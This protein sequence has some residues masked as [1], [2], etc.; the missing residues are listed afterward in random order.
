MCK[1]SKPE[2]NLWLNPDN[3]P[4]SQTPLKFSITY[5]DIKRAEDRLR[6][7]APLLALLFPELRMTNGIIES[8]LI[9]ISSSSPLPPT[10]NLWVKADHALPIAGSIKARG[11]I[12]EVLEFAEQLALKEGLITTQSSYVELSQPA[13]KKLFSQYTIAVGSTGNLGLSIGVTAAA[14]GFKAVV[15]MSKEAKSWKKTHLRQREVTVIEHEGD[16]A[17][18]VQRGREQAN[19]NPHSY[20][21]DDERSTSLFCGYAVAAFRLQHQLLQQHIPIDNEHPLFVYIPCGVGGAPAGVAYGL[22]LIFNENVHCF[23]IEPKQSAC[24]SLQ[25]QHPNIPGLSVYDMGQSNHTE[26]DGLAVPVASELAISA[27]K[28]RLAGVVTIDDEYLFANLYALHKHNGIKVEP[29]AAAALSG[30][31]ALLTTEAGQKY[32]NQL[33]ED[34]FQAATHLV[35]TT[36]GLFVPDDE[37][38]SFLT[39][40]EKVYQTLYQ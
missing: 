12:H 17:L 29:S 6:R 16:Y 7:F 26:A 14:L 1:P 23:F 34:S 9:H 37:Y 5:S 20:F 18:A 33:K 21:I 39:R 3:N 22:K 25:L 32:T 30:P 27:M 13:A 4:Y 36:G 2:L 19:C 35:W 11:G 24:F 31:A 38:Q 8:E 28:N 10:A 40:G 15:H